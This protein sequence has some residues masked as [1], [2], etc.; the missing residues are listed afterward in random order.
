[1]SNTEDEDD[2]NRYQT[3][4]S[5]CGCQLRW[6][7][8]TGSRPGPRDPG[9]QKPWIPPGSG[10]DVVNIVKDL[11]LNTKLDHRWKIDANNNVVYFDTLGNPA[12]RVGIGKADPTTLILPQWV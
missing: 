7:S 4:I 6:D 3:T 11:A 12:R 5:F 9:L 8:R 10:L 1:M 2:P